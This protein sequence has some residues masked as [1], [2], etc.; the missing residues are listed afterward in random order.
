MTIYGECEARGQRLPVT[1]SQLDGQGCALTSEAS[2]ELPQGEMALW[3]GAIGPLAVIAMQMDANHTNA[4]FA[5][6]LD[7]RILEHFGQ[8]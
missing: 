6:P 1:I 3:I 5:Q 4:A 7:P 2:H 8:A